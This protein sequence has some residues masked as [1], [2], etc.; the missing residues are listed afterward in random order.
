MKLREHRGRLHLRNVGLEEIADQYG[1][2][3][4]LYDVD[5]MKER[6]GRVR[7]AFSGKVEVFYAVKAK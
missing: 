5:F 2:P 7:E 4:Y 6:I 3:F 1:T